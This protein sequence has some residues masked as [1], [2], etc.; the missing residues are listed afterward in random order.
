MSRPLSVPEKRSKSTSDKNHACERVKK[1]D[2]GVEI[3]F[4]NVTQME[5]SRISVRVC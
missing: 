2:A 4:L 5:Y 1:M 3:G